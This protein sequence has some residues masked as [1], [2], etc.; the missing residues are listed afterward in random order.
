MC[1]LLIFQTQTICYNRN[2]SLKYLSSTT[3][4]SVDIGIRKFEF[5]TKTQFLCPPI[6]V[7][8]LKTIFG[9]MK[10]PSKFPTIIRE[11]S[12]YKKFE[13]TIVRKICVYSVQNCVLRI[14]IYTQISIYLL[15]LDSRFVRHV[16]SQPTLYTGDKESSC[17]LSVLSLTHTFTFTLLEQ[18]IYSLSL[19]S[20]AQH[21]TR[22]EMINVHQKSW[23]WTHYYS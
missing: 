9:T 11:L 20:S 8:V 17:F 21:K 13:P 7:I 18:I 3:L 4:G 16:Y 2:H 10:I 19:C 1:K 5:V 22:P 23:Q 14:I 15:S 12:L 6:I